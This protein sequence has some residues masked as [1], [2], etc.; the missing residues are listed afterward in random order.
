MSGAHI[1]TNAVLPMRHRERRYW[2]RVVCYLV[3]LS[4]T[5]TENGGTLGFLPRAA[6]RIGTHGQLPYPLQPEM[7]S[8]YTL[9]PAST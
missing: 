8:C 3:L 2:E 7:L 4:G 6:R 1:P 5:E 9:C